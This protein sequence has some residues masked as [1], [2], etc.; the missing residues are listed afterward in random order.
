MFAIDQH[1][2]ET[3]LR[4]DIGDAG[5]HEAGADDADLPELDGG[6]SAGRR[7]PLFSSC[8]ETKRERIIEA[9]SVRRILAK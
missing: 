8:I 6:T 7:A 2:V 3:G 4:G 9:A 1:D 5:A